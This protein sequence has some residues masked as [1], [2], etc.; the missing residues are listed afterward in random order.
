MLSVSTSNGMQIHFCS[1]REAS[2]LFHRKSYWSSRELN[3]TV[4]YSGAQK[5]ECTKWHLFLFSLQ[6]E[7]STMLCSN[8]FFTLPDLTPLQC[9]INEMEESFNGSLFKCYEKTHTMYIPFYFSTQMEDVLD[10]IYFCPR[11]EPEK[12]WE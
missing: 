11:S 3:E 5:E 2:S 1:D 9:E 8:I 6:P 7:L 4:D 12:L 10:S